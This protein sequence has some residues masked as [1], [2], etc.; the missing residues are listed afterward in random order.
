MPYGASTHPKRPSAN[1]RWRMSPRTSERRPP[2]PARERSRLAARRGA[3]EHRRR[4]DRCRPAARRRG[5]A[6]AQSGRFRIRARAP[7]RGHPRRPAARTARRG[8]RASARSPSRRRAR[9]RP[10]LSSLR[11]CSSRGFQGLRSREFEDPKNRAARGV[12]RCRRWLHLPPRCHEELGRRRQT[13]CRPAARAP[14]MSTSG[15]SPTKADRAGW[16]WS[17][18][19]A[20]WKI[21]G[22]GLATP[23]ADEIRIVSK[24]G[25]RDRHS[26]FRLCIFTEPFVMS[27]SLKPEARRAASVSVT[28]GKREQALG[29][30]AR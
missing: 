6:A 13:V 23:S 22:S 1:G 26:S 4:I 27:P 14:A 28:S 12:H 9:T 7:A 18:P 25:E 21:S 16:A 10:S 2:A 30:P 17:R 29:N 5:R 19:N 8:G 11:V 15:W 3:G 20:R 24:A